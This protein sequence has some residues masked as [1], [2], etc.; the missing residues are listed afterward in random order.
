MTTSFDLKSF[1]KDLE[2]T[3]EAGRIAFTGL[4]KNELNSL[5]GLS[6][7]EIDAITPGITDLQKYEELITVVKAASQ[8]NLDQAALKEQILKLGDVAVTIAR[9]VPSLA[10]IL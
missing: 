4:Y 7:T 1:E 10:K 6:K 3:L 2:E 9:C 5:S 8:A